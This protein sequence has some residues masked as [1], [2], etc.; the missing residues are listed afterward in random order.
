MPS[1]SVSQYGTH[2]VSLVPVKHGIHAAMIKAVDDM[3]DAGQVPVKI[4]T[5]LQNKYEHDADMEALIPSSEQIRSRKQS[6]VV[7]ESKLSSVETNKQLTDLL[8]NLKVF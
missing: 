4:R 1:Y 6:K 8:N 2:S 7:Q 5:I 3:I